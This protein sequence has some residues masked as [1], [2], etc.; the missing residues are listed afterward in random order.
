MGKLISSG[1]GVY[2]VTCSRNYNFI[3][4]G[5]IDCLFYNNLHKLSENMGWD[6]GKC[7]KNLILHHQGL[8]KRCVHY[9]KYSS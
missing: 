7:Y 9:M 3:V 4:F 2:Q 5:A 6:N 1:T 8:F